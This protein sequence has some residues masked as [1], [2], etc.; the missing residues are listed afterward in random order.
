MV[1]LI[2]QFNFRD[3]VVSVFQA[4]DDFC[5]N[6]KTKQDESNQTTPAEIHALNGT[7]LVGNHNG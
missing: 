6:V 4:Q 3:I 2:I 5:I 1:F 7:I